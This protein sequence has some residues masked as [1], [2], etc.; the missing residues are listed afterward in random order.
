MRLIKRPQTL[1]SRAFHVNGISMEPVFPNGSD[2]RI[3]PVPYFFHNP[4][5]GD[6]VGMCCP[7]AH[8]RLELKRVVGLPGECVSWRGGNIWI[9]GTKLEEPYLEYTTVEFNTMAEG[10]VFEMLEL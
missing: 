4:H 6:V 7:E 10:E 9:N 2:V 1:L 5:R 3:S 8:E